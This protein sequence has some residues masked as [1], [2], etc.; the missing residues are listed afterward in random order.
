MTRWPARPCTP[1]LVLAPLLVPAVIGLPATLS[2][3]ARRPVAIGA[4]TWIALSTALVVV[5]GRLELHYLSMMVPPLAL[6]APA[7]FV[8]HL[9]GGHR[10][11]ARGAIVAGLLAVAFSISTLVSTSET[12]MALDARAAQAERSR[13]VGGWVNAHTP[14]EA[15]IFVW[16]NA[17]SV[18]LDADRAPASAYVYL[19]PLTTPGFVTDELIA[20]VV[21]EWTALR[22]RPSSTPARPR[23]ALPACRRCWW[24]V[25]RWSL[26]DATWT[27]WSPCAPSFA[28]ATCRRQ[29]WT[30]GPSTCLVKPV[31]SLS[32]R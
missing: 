12:A 2:H 5:Q 6:L 31:A 17:P 10:V 24:T 7:G 23:R 21:E 28:T 27:S 1:L 9:R 15:Q 11:V 14:T 32:S 22:R 8:L 30:A 3:A 18:Y 19:L 16:G 29:R 13:A 20:S 26:T 25:R 4:L